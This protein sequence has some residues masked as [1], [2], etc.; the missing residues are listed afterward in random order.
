MQRD[1]TGRWPFLSFNKD[2]L[3]RPLRSEQTLPFSYLSND[4]EA[5]TATQSCRVTLTDPADSG[6]LSKFTPLRDHG[7]RDSVPAHPQLSR[8]CSRIRTA[9]PRH[10]QRSSATAPL[11]QLPRFS[12]REPALPLLAARVY[13]RA[14]TAWGR[15]RVLRGSVIPQEPSA[16]MPKGTGDTRRVHE[17]PPPRDTIRVLRGSVIPQEPPAAIT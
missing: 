13:A 17:I 16:V 14:A 9:S 10:C 7:R 11:R 4:L 1:G 2:S 6:C 12:V 5:E 8:H 15:I 3:K